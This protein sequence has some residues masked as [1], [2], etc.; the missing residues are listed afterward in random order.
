MSMT[1]ICSTY[2]NQSRP[3]QAASDE[4]SRDVL[5]YFLPQYYFWGYFATTQTTNDIF[6]NANDT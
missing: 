6:F 2:T 4:N 1:T 3:Y 5:R